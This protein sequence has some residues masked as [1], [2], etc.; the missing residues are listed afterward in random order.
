MFVS[1]RCRPFVL[2]LIL[3]FLLRRRV[4]FVLSPVM[5]SSLRLSEIKDA[6][7]NTEKQKLL[8]CIG[9]ESKKM[10]SRSRRSAPVVAPSPTPPGGEGVLLVALQA[11]VEGGGAGFQRK[12]YQKGS[13]VEPA[14]FFSNCFSRNI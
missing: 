5:P 10:R 6:A 2:P 8:S 9:E 7:I 12:K 4:P 13:A 1:Q 14:G 3:L 11:V